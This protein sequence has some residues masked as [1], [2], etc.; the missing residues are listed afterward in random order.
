MRILLASL[1]AGSLLLPGAAQAGHDHDSDRILAGALVG[2]AIGAVIAAEHPPVVIEYAP[3]VSWR[4]PRVTHY[5]PVAPYRLQ[6]VY[7]ERRG[8][9][10]HHHRDHRRSHRDWR[11]R[12]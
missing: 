2:G 1:L 5:H 4:V 6:P 3:P 10:H 11:R 8:W 12:W 7:P 9:R